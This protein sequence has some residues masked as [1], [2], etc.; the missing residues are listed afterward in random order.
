MTH[1]FLSSPITYDSINV[2]GGFQ[3]S[4]YF[5]QL[6]SN[7]WGNTYT[8]FVI[9]GTRYQV[10]FYLWQIGL[11]LK[12]IKFQNILTSIADTLNSKKKLSCPSTIVKAFQSHLRIQEIYVPICQKNS[13]YDT[14]HQILLLKKS[15]VCSITDTSKLFSEIYKRDKKIIKE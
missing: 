2:K 10:S 8:M 1:C 3:P 5:L 7:S 4:I 11:V 15:F 12:N 6:F 13:E 14:A 9:L